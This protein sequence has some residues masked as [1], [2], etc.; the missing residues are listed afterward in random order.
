M[1]EYYKPTL[2]KPSFQSL[3]WLRF[4]SLHTLWGILER[5]K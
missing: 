1:C 2:N 4:I 3:N 5:P